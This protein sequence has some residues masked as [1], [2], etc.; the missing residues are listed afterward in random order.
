MLVVGACDC[1]SASGAT[2]SLSLG[3]L[4]LHRTFRHTTSKASC[5]YASPVV[6]SNSVINPRENDTALRPMGTLARARRLGAA[7]PRRSL[8]Q[9][10][11]ISPAPI[12]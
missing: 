1:T 9:S 11:L 3:P 5:C 10:K 8:M 2:F 12:C 7:P 6:L 4:R